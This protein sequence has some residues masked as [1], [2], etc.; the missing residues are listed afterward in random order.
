MTKP[1]LQSVQKT[2]ETAR[3]LEPQDP[4]VLSY[5]AEVQGDIG[6]VDPRH[7]EAAAADV[8]CRR[9]GDGEG[10]GHRDGRVDRVPPSAQHGQTRFGGEG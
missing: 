8:S 7:H 4:G 2:L 6:A 1:V 10:H 5:L 9:V 3:D